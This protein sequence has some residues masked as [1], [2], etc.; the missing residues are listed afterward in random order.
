MRLLDKL[1]SQL[2]AEKVDYK[3]TKEFKPFMVKDTFTDK[4]LNIVNDGNNDQ[5]FGIAQGK[6][7]NQD[8]YMDLSAKDWFVFNENYGTSEE[9]HLVKYIDKLKQKYSKVYLLRNERHFKLFNFDDGRVFEPDFV[10]FLIKDDISTVMHYQVFIEP[11]GSHLIKHDEW[12]NNFLMQL[13]TEH[14]IEQLW[15]DRNYI[16][17]G[18]PFYNKTDTKPEFEKEF[19]VLL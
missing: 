3:G 14:K 19:S 18:M 2:Q 5:E 16:V 1:S 13:K 15:K 11:K 12:K 7:T 10:L 17:W 6:T 4:T 9:K 8:L